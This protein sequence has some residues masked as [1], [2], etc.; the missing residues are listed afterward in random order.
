VVAMVGGRDYRASQ[1]NRAVNAERQ[2]GSAFK[3]FVY[4]AALRRGLTPDDLIDASPLDIAGWDPEN[5]G[6]RQYGRVTLAE[7]FAHSI[8]TAAARLA[9]QVGL[10]EVITAARDLGIDRPLPEVP[11]LALGAVELTLVDLTAAFASVRADRKRVK[12]WGIV[13]FAAG[14]EDQIRPL[15]PPAGTQQSLDPYQRPLVEMLQL[16][17]QRGTGRAAALDGFAAGKTG[18]S[19]DYRD[20]WFIGFNEDLVVGVWV[21]NDDRTP[22]R[23]VTG[24]SLP[25]MI[26]KRFMVEAIPIFRQER[27]VATSARERPASEASNRTAPDRCD[28]QACANAYESFRPSDCTYQPFS[29]PRRF[30]DRAEDTMAMPASEVSAANPTGA[31]CNVEACARTYDTFNA[32]DC[33]YQPYGGGSR[34]LCVK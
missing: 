10:R 31:Q 13:G 2:P 12:P 17:V 25:A 18:T 9:Q 21:G 5:Y 19:Q 6:D 16:V 24:G 22:M 15:G 11:S 7:A 20:A 27:L 29:G 30:C 28:Y 34:R 26:W 14:G 1:F 33:S 3:L 23:N 8:N 32:S 4:L